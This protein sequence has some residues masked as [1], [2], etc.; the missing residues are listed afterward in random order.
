MPRPLFNV[1]HTVLA[2]FQGRGCNF[3]NRLQ[4]FASLQSISVILLYMYDSKSILRFNLL[5]GNTKVHLPITPTIIELA[6]DR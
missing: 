4:T 1:Y 3:S 6:V 5:E 2:L